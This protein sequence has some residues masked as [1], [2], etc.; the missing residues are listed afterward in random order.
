MAQTLI[1][2][3]TWGVSGLQT[4]EVEIEIWDLHI[5]NI[6]GLILYYHNLWDCRLSI[7]IFNSVIIEI[8]KLLMI[9]NYFI[10]YCLR[11]R[12]LTPTITPTYHVIPHCACRAL[13]DSTEKT[14]IVLH[15]Y[16]DSKTHD[17]SVCAVVADS[18]DTFHGHVIALGEQRD[19]CDVTRG[20]RIVSAVDKWCHNGR[21][22]MES[23]WWN[24]I[25]SDW[26]QIP[27]NYNVAVETMGCQK[28]VSIG[29]AM[30]FHCHIPKLA[31]IV[32]VLGCEKDFSST[33]ALY[34]NFL[35]IVM[36]RKKAMSVYELQG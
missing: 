29:F 2:N 17:N 31:Q 1:K 13:E 35:N 36:H 27:I 15:N 34:L 33:K 14:A 22:L 3:I 7:V 24:I 8:K 9:T 5:L 20:N 25:V 11:W 23:W 16:F 6:W 10:C 12:D 30:F 4:K 28:Q 21:K 26:Y 18:R 19:S 32:H